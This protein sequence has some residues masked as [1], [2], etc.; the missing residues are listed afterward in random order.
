MGL[1]RLTPGGPAPLTFHP[2]QAEFPVPDRY[3]L[4]LKTALASNTGGPYTATWDRAVVPS[5]GTIRGARFVAVGLSSNART[6]TV[7]LYNQ[8]DAPAAGSNTATS[9]LVSP[10]TLT[11]DSAGAAGTISEA[12]ARVDAGDILELRTYADTIA[13][14]PAFIGLSAVVEIERD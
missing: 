5:A 14:T 8:P 6:N 10:V 11:N 1:G 9:V 7:D 12:G 3:N 2:Q 13:A 4:E